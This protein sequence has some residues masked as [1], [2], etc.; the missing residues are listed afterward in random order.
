MMAGTDLSSVEE[1]LLARAVNNLEEA[2]L[3][4]TELTGQQLEMILTVLTAD[5][6]QLKNLDIGSN[7]IS[8]VEPYLLARA[9]T[10]LGNMKL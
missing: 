3:G 10:S 6:S 4:D 9:V 7:N 1:G 8:L 2:N 5:L